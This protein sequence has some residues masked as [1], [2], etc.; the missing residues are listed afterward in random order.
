MAAIAAY[1]DELAS[2]YDP[3]VQGFI[4]HLALSSKMVNQAPDDWYYRNYYD[5]V[6]RE[7]A[8]PR[9][10]EVTLPDYY[11]P[12]EPRQCFYNSWCLV[13]ETPGLVY[14]EGFA[15]CRGIPVEHAWVEE[16]DGSIIDTTWAAITDPGDEAIYFGVRFT[17]EMAV[18][19]SLQT[20]WSSIL[21][22]DNYAD[23][24]ILRRGLK[25]HERLAIDLN[26]VGT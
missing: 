16:V 9:I 15:Q 5:L 26:E 14:V 21:Q 20:G 22:G 25:M 12:M 13:Q 17:S 24:Q 7:A 10:Q 3:E 19:L 1:A 23:N 6:L 8:E 11:E 4:S 2:T 18:K